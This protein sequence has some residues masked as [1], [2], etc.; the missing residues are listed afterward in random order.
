MAQAMANSPGVTPAKAGGSSSPVRGGG[1]AEGWW[2]GCSGISASPSTAL[3]AVPLP[4]RGR[5]WIPAFA[6]MTLLSLTACERGDAPPADNRQAAAPAP[7][8]AQPETEVARAERLVREA[9]GNGQG[10]TF[11]PPQRTLSDGVPILCGEY[12][13][14]AERQRYIVVNGESTFIEPRMRAGEMD[15]AF[16]EF[17]GGERG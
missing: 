7:K 1:P 12:V 6:G 10:L 9:A 2:R 4:L 8:A 3:H 11:T 17:C 16:N 13:R 5:N 14:G 15:R